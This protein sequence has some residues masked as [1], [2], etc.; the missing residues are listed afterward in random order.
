[1]KMYEQLA[2]WWPLLSAPEEYA[3]EAVF[4]AV[5]LDALARR[6]VRTILELGSGGGNNA[7]H[8]AQRYDMV[9]VDRSPAML[10]VSRALNP[11]CEHIEGDMRSVRLGRTFDAVLVHDAI[12]YMT[13]EAD[14]AA[15]I[16]T[17]AA[18]LQPG[19]AV[20]LVPDDTWE[21][22]TPETH[23]GGRDGAGRAMRYLSWSHP[24]PP[25][26]RS[27]SRPARSARS[28]P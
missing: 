22:F 16:E 12:M 4:I 18:H 27:I 1:M 11:G 5:M 3:D 19:G 24:P 26:A 6:P 23:S 13:T 9:L 17:A 25:G 2:A 20:L 14:L 7:S 8:L 15:V 10:A 21:T 28:S